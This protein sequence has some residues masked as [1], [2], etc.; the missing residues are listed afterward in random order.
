MDVQTSLVRVSSTETLRI[1]K[2][3]LKN[4]LFK[5]NGNEILY[6]G[7]MYDVKE[8][9]IDGEFVVFHCI[10]DNTENKLL[11]GLD[12]QVKSNSFPGENKKQNDFSK[13]PVKDLFCSVKKP[14]IQFSSLHL[15]Q[16][17][18]YNLQSVILSP[19]PPPPPES[20]LS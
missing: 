18:I 10:K 19:L 2:S 20:S 16:T 6:K 15:F 13:N 5:E 4:I 7:E 1:P 3:E 11:A 14:A 9:F 17:T 8:K 12:N